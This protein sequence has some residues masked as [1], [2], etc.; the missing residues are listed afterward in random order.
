MY[1]RKRDRRPDRPIGR[2][3]SGKQP[4]HPR[5]E[6]WTATRRYIHGRCGPRPAS[7]P[8]RTVACAVACSL[9]A[10]HSAEIR[11][12]WSRTPAAASVPGSF[13]YC[14]SRARPALAL[15]L[16]RPVPVLLR[17]PARRVAFGT[18]SFD[19]K[20]PAA[21]QQQRRGMGPG[22]AMGSTRQ[23]PCSISRQ[24]KMLGATA[25][26]Q[27]ELSDCYGLYTC[28][29]TLSS[30]ARSHDRPVTLLNSCWS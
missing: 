18:N 1:G 17:C 19:A 28:P 5:V 23:P 11:R 30:C 10:P 25:T 3:E 16:D 12:L 13:H 20:I 7:T 22:A 24:Y 2:S 8:A 21:S 15:A 29:S 6:T 26:W 14:G 27:G 4:A 9:D